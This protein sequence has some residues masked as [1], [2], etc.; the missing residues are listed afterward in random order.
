VV[1]EFF[2]YAPR[3]TR[4]TIDSPH[5]IVSQW[6]VGVVGVDD[7][8]APNAREL[9]NHPV[10]QQALEEAWRDSRP[11]EPDARHEEGGWIYLDTTTGGILVRRAAA[12][13]QAEVNLDNPAILPGAILVGV[14]HTH[15]NPTAE[16]W[17]GGP[18]EADR[19]ADERDGVPDL[20]RADDGIHVSGPESR[21]G[22]LG[23]GPTYPPLRPRQSE[24]KPA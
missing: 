3:P 14:F 9:L 17:V 24:S 15:P 23:D 21:R 11:E 6:I 7:M 5:P 4:G 13:L 18:S 22:G 12:G 19:R 20:I 16:G 10:V 1:T 8:R 2:G